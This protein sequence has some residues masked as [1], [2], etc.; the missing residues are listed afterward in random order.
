VPD[1]AEAQP[2]RGEA[3]NFARVLMALPVPQ[4]AGPFRR[5]ADRVVTV[6]GAPSL[7]CAALRRPR[8]NIAQ[9]VTYCATG[10][11]G[12][13]LTIHT[14]VF[15]SAVNAGVADQVTTRFLT[16]TLRMLGTGEGLLPRAA[17]V[18][19]AP[20]AAKPLPAA[21]TAPAED[22]AIPDRL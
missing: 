13:L 18:A 21:A 10:L 11:A 17:V 4:G 22:D 16:D 12:R 2:A 6:P 14:S 19:A 7:R 15:Y 5:E 9:M 20:G 8:D 1:G 3:D